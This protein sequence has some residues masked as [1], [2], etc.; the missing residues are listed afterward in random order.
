MKT[1]GDVLDRFDEICRLIDNIH[2]CNSGDIKIPGFDEDDLI[3]ILREY[4]A[5]LRSLPMK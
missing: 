3:R 1:V 5:V 2:G 4:C